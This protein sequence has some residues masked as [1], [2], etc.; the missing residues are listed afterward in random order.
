M[1]I[2]DFRPTNPFSGIVFAVAMVAVGTAVV[3]GLVGWYVVAGG[4]ALGAALAL[5]VVRGMEAQ[6]IHD[7]ADARRDALEDA[8][9]LTRPYEPEGDL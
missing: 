6:R 2:T 5:L 4:C 9:A 3:T 7:E 8:A 1:R